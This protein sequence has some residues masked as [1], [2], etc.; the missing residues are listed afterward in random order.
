MEKSIFLLP[1]NSRLTFN[2]TLNELDDKDKHG[3]KQILQLLKQNQLDSF[4]GNMKSLLIL[5]LNMFQVITSN[6][7]YLRIFCPLRFLQYH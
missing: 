3:V 4:H 1:Y 2:V 5:I 7:I 6:Q